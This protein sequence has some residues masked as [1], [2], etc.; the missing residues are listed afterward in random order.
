MDTR[1]GQA[2]TATADQRRRWREH[3]EQHAAIAD[4]WGQRGYRPPTPTFPILSEDLRSLTCSA[5]TR[6]GTPCKLTALYSSGRCKWH[7]GLSTGPTTEAGKEQARI[8]GRKGGRPRK[9]EPKF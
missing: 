7:G 3:H 6:A 2:M 5:K 4:Q 9:E 1:E 8:N